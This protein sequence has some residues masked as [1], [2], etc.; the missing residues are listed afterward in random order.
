MKIKAFLKSFL[1]ATIGA[2]C[3]AFAVAF[4][5]D[6]YKIAPGGITGF[7]VII[8][9]LFPAVS[10]GT[11]V[12]LMNVPLLILALLRFGKKFVAL[13]V[14]ATSFMS[15]LMNVLEPLSA[16]YGIVTDDLIVPAL[17]GAVLDAIGLGLVYRAG[18]CTGG[19]DIVIKF[20]RQK[21]RHI[22]TGAMSLIVNA[23]VVTATLLAFGNFEIAVY[24]AIAMTL[25]SFILD[26][27]LYGGE[28]A[29][30]VYIISDK[31]SEITN[32]ILTKI[33]IGVTLLHGE[34]AYLNKEKKVILCAAKKQTFP[35]I[36]DIVKN[37]DPSA[38]M[39][40]TN[41]TEIFGEGY[42]SQFNEEL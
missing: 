10:T 29:K 2:A 7:A 37:T 4:F 14:Y 20:L 33:N 6:P 5:Y 16:S 30:L 23:V 17:C 25:S 34:G 36:R 41:A 21:Y 8:S 26:K 39:I 11:V 24:S 22:R 40:I 9:H 1:L 3:F 28:G 27:V 13:T 19:S 35:K 38:F 31:H 18:G 15:L 32:E 42:K 12:F